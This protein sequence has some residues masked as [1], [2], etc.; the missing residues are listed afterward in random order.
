[1][2]LRAIQPLGMHRLGGFFARCIAMTNQALFPHEYAMRDQGRRCRLDGF[3]LWRLLQ[4][5]K[6]ILCEGCHIFICSNMALLANE[7]FRMRRGRRSEAFHDKPG[8]VAIQAFPVQNFVRNHRRRINIVSELSP[9]IFAVV[10]AVNT[11]ATASYER[12]KREQKNSCY[13]FHK[14][15]ITNY[16]SLFESLCRSHLFDCHRTFFV[17]GLF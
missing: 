15:S 13:Y 8:F 2:A 14:P 12:C 6:V 11:V 5:C 16:E 1:M 4:S 17:I 10:F 9:G 3:E 7:Q